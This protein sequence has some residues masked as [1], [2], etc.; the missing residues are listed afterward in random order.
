MSDVYSCGCKVGALNL[1]DRCNKH[2]LWSCH[3]DRLP[4]GY[5]YVEAG[6]RCPEC[7]RSNLPTVGL[8]P[9]LSR[10]AYER[11]KGHPPDKRGRENY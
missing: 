9:A 1:D 2:A 11:V 7:F 3:K 4:P 5:P 10:L 6:Q 8:G